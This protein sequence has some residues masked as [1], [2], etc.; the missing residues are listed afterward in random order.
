[1]QA[2]HSQACEQAIIETKVNHFD[3]L[4]QGIINN[5]ILPYLSGNNIFYFGITNVSNYNNIVQYPGYLAIVNPLKIEY[6]QS[7]LDS[8]DERYNKVGFI[9]VKSEI[10]SLC[11]F[12]VCGCAS[13][14]AILVRLQQ[15][16]QY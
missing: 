12:C 16:A 1:M 14:Y 6:L 4:D 5:H 13:A 11:D 10:P 15:L 9:A 8:I 7:R 2:V 3:K